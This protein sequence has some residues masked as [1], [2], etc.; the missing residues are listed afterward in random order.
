MKIKDKIVYQ[1]EQ[2]K[3]MM[4]RV[5]H[6]KKSQ[7]M[8]L[9]LKKDRNRM[10]KLMMKILVGMNLMETNRLLLMQPY[11]LKTSSSSYK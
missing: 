11:Q 3:K 10:I 4:K 2:H 7:K 1:L 5:I 8:I 6:L 9:H